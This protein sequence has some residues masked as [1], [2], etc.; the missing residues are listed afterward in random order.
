[1]WLSRRK[2]CE[3]SAEINEEEALLKLLPKSVERKTGFCVFCQ[4]EWEE[5]PDEIIALA[6]T[7]L[8][9]FVN[10]S[11]EK[12]ALILPVRVFSE[13]CHKKPKLVLYPNKTWLKTWHT[14]HWSHR[15]NYRKYHGTWCVVYSNNWRLTK[16][17]GFWFSHLSFV[18][19]QYDFRG[20][21]F[22][23]CLYGHGYVAW[24]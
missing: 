19:L 10:R 13:N 5:T 22:A 12:A 4:K 9:E 18:L 1:M 7:C 20:Q 17:S 24:H 2:K 14:T 16:F 8:T 6:I 15:F 11:P 3:S 23:A 21:S